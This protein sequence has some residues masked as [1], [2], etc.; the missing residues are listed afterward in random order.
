MSTVLSRREA[1]RQVALLMGGA[2]SAPAVLG[3]LNGCSAKPSA[4]F[5]PVFLTEAQGTIVA[6]IAEIMIPRTDT[7]GAVDVGVPAFIDR[8]L[9]DTYPKEDQERFLAGLAAFEA[10]SQKEH[11]RE[12]LKVETDKRAA[13]VQTVHDAAVAV[14]QEASRGPGQ[15]PRPFILMMKELTLLGYFTSEP[16]ATQVLQWTPLP[17]PYQGCIPLEQAGKGRTWAEEQSRRF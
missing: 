12:F 1:L 11:Q 14:E 13:L 10:Q 4:G 2:L 6:D 3:V 7:P 5:K 17:G 9:K 16:G 15:F 8:M